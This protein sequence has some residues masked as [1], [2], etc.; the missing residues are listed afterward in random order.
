MGSNP[1][2]LLKYFLLSVAKGQLILKGLFGI[3]KFFQKFDI[4]LLGKKNEFIR[5]FFGRIVGL[6]E[7]LRFFLTFKVLLSNL[8]TVDHFHVLQGEV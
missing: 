8:N 1:G 6:K 2:Y 7:P 3:L 4:V 5:S